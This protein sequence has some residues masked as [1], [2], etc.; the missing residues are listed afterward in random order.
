MTDNPED[1]Q[2]YPYLVEWV[3]SANKW[4]RD[5]EIYEF[6]PADDQGLD[7][8]GRFSKEDGYPG[9]PEFTTQ[10]T[11][12]YGSEGSK[13]W[14]LHDGTD[15]L[16]LPDFLMGASS[17]RCTIGW[18]LGR[19]P[20][21]EKAEVLEYMNEVCITCEGQGSYIVAGS[22]EEVDC[23]VCEDGPIYVELEHTSSK[24]N[25][26]SGQER[27]KAIGPNGI[28]YFKNGPLLDPGLFEMSL[29]RLKNL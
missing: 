5:Y 20:H 4:A 22:D 15:R 25:Q 23:L 1:W 21:G 7:P 8:S 19:I 2:N 3:E 26:V 13:V 17:S 27:N 24:T 28:L 10:S 16:V 18:Y 9:L 29:E 11:G 6:M 12:G 14:T